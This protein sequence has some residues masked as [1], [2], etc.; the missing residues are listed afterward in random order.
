M[1]I[2]VIRNTNDIR[3]LSR[4][5]RNRGK[6]IALVPTMGGLHEGHLSLVRRGFEC[7]DEVMPTIFVNA[8]QFAAHEDFGRYPRNEDADLEQLS[9]TGVNFVYAPTH[10][11][12]YEPRFSTTIT[13][14]GP[15]KAG[16]EDRFRP[17]FFDGVATVV[18]KLFIRC[19]PDY[20]VLGEKDYQQLLVVKQMT[21]DLDL[22][23]EVI[24]M[25]TIRE[26]DG[27]AMSTR[28]RYL[29]KHE[30]HQATALIRSLEQAAEKIRNGTDQQTATKAAQ[31]SLL[32]LGFKVDYVT[33]RN[34]ETLNV[35]VDRDEPLRLLAAAHLG[36]TRL[37][38][39][40]QV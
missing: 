38:D 18:A 11:D 30:R 7:A 10:D 8:K 19:E 25:P 26:D 22:P 17:Q 39:N 4:H 40:I 24:G 9:G 36:A 5:L 27:L 33:A 15:A 2:E 6:R 35:P 28:N 13:L 32:T 37:I 21:R 16:L 1:N 20:A 23:L 29:S 14:T 34:A 12:M 3:E 31:R